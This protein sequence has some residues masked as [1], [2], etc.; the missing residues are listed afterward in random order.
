M[1][2]KILTLTVLSL[3]LIACTSD[4]SKQLIG[5]WKSE[6][7]SSLDGKPYTFLISENK[8]SVGNDS[9]DIKFSEENGI[10]II[11]RLGANEPILTAQVISDDKVKFTNVL[12]NGEIFVRTT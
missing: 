8:M 7:N 11:K 4:A 12:F 2:K 3:L 6:Q 1:I 5:A 9:V 10:V